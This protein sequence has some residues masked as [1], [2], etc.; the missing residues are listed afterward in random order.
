M[1][2]E[3]KKP[4]SELWWTKSLSLAASAARSDQGWSSVLRAA[5][6]EAM[7]R[8]ELTPGAGDIGK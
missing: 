7:S 2:K 1:K 3:M 4:G 6:R 5:L 8:A